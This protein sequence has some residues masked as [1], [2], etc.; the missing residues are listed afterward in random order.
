MEFRAVCSPTEM[1]LP[2]K[3]LQKTPW[4]CI[5]INNRNLIFYKNTP[6]FDGRSLCPPL[7]PPAT[8]LST[9]LRRLATVEDDT[10]SCSLRWHGRSHALGSEDALI[11]ERCRSGGASPHALDRSA[12]GRQGQGMLQ[13]TILSSA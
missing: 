5:A 12:G 7:A 1:S 10:Y 2:L 8:M 6:G 13:L 4:V 9:I 3:H 11:H